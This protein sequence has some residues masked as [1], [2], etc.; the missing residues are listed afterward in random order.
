MSLDGK[1]REPLQSPST[2]DREA[3]VFFRY[4]GAPEGATLTS[5][6]YL[7]GKYQ[8]IRTVAV[9]LPAGEGRGHLALRLA[10]GAT[11]PAGAYRVDVV[12]ANTV[13]GSAEF[14][15]SS[16]ASRLHHKE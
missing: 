7:D 8:D 5:D 10:P 11:F 9:A 16:E 13:V 6:W 2:D 1:P 12:Y 15:V 4:E 14:T 3:Y